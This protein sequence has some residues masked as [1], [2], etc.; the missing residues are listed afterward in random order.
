[1]MAHAAADALRAGE[2]TSVELTSAVLERVASVEADVG[3]YLTLMAEEALGQAAAADRRLA[4]GDAPALCGIPIALKDVLSTAGVRTTCA[5]RILE[6]FAPPYDATVVK[7]LQDAGAV[8]IGKTN[9]DEF[10]MGSSNE[11]SA[12]HPVHNPWRLDRVPGGSSGGSAAAVAADECLLALGSDT[13]GSI[14]QP[15]SF[16]GIVGLKPTYGRVSRYGL[17]AFASSLDQIGPLAKDVED[18]ALMLQAIAGHDPKDSTSIDATPP[19]FAEGL[20]EGV[21]GMKIGVPAEYFVD[22]MEPGVEQVV[23]AAIER[24]AGLGAEVVAVSLPHTSYALTTYYIIA[25]AEASA[26]LARYN[27]VKYGYA[28]LDATDVDELMMN[29]RGTGFGDEVKRRI[30]LGT[31][32]LSSGYYDAYYKKAQQVRT[33]IKRD[34]DAA[35]ADV[36]VLVTPT[37][38]TVAFELGAKTQDPLAMYLSDVMTIPANMAGLPG[39]SIPGGFSDGMPVG[40]QF[41]APAMEEARLL[42]AAYALERELDVAA[43]APAKVV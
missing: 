36:D 19:D 39:I 33:L 6:D 28:D 27:G 42:R 9:M 13:G 2:I 26:N 12:F 14:R 43:A 25:P 41:M 16:C 34:F 37:S 20:D 23:R 18:A 32:A 8:V 3:A 21:K 30:V 11:N 24:L 31:Y 7:K 4:A 1:M 38:P 10:A 22:G 15:A 29:S 5:S 35:F 40:V 17:V